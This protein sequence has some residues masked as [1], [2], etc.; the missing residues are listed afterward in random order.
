M[1]RQRKLKKQL[2]RAPRHSSITTTM[3]FYV[4]VIDANKKRLSGDSEEIWLFLSA[5]RVAVAY[6][7]TATT[8]AKTP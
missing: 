4:F 7:G 5:S 2:S 8:T 1:L 3:K 6:C